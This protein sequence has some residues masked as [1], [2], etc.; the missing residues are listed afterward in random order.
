MGNLKHRLISIC[1]IQIDQ[2]RKVNPNLSKPLQSMKTM[3]I[4]IQILQSHLFPNN[5]PNHQK[6]QLSLHH[7]LA[8]GKEVA[9]EVEG[10]NRDRADDEEAMVEAEDVGASNQ[11]IPNH[12]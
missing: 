10:S 8:I 6:R 2:N 1:L 11:T 7:S 9:A 12:H 5:Q 4:K 3:T